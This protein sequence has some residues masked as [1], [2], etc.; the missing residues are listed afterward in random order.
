[1]WALKAATFLTLAYFVLG[2]Q[3]LDY[4]FQLMKCAKIAITQ[5][6]PELN[7]PAHTPIH[8]R[9]NLSWSGDIGVAKININLTNGVWYGLPDWE[10]SANQTTED[11]STFIGY[12]FKLHW[13]KMNMSFDYALTTNELIFKQVQHGHMTLKWADTAW[14]GKLNVTRPGLSNVAEKVNE[15]LID[16]TV[17]DLDVSLTGLGLFNGP[18]ATAIGTTVKNGLNLHL[19]GNAVGDFIQMR[20]NTIWW[21]TGKV[22]KLTQWCQKLHESQNY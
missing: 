21:S 2:G 8:I 5:G 4:G 17:E 13:Q 16:W 15:A 14:T 20:L 18:F 3:D 9:S 7:V 11:G 19:V 12:D 6:I 10:L 1:M 22:W